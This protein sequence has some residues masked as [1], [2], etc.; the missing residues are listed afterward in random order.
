VITLGACP[1][2]PWARGPRAPCPGGARPGG[3][4]RER[5][6]EGQRHAQLGPPDREGGAERDEGGSVQG[7][8]GE[9]D[10]RAPGEE[11]G[12][13]CRDAN[14]F[15]GER[16]E[17]ELEDGGTPRA[18]D[19]GCAGKQGGKSTRGGGKQQDARNDHCG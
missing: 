11:G 13:R 8:G 5:A 12:K 3:D 17:D 18:K 14:G 15:C 16:H 4:A 2:G 1:P 7:D 19:S 9:E 6:R 10:G